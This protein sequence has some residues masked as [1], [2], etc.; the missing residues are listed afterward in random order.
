MSL[1]AWISTV[2]LVAAIGLTLYSGRELKMATERLTV[3][4]R[5]YERSRSVWDAI[6][7]KLDEDSLAAVQAFLDE[8]SD[9]TGSIPSDYHDPAPNPHPGEKQNG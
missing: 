1:D 8:E 6:D 2:M 3:S 4:R 5:Y 9:H 7:A